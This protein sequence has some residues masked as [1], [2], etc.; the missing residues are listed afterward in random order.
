MDIEKGILCLLF[1]IFFKNE[2]AETFFD[3]LTS[4][5]GE[6]R[7]KCTTCKFKSSNKKSCSIHMNTHGVELN[8]TAEMIQY[9]APPNF[10]MVFGYICE[11]CHYVQLGKNEVE[12]HCNIYHL[13]SYKVWYQYFTKYY[14]LTLLF[15]FYNIGDKKIDARPLWLWKPFIVILILND[16]H[17][18]TA[19]C[20]VLSWFS[21]LL[22]AYKNVVHLLYVMFIGLQHG[23]YILL[24]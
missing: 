2:Y 3:H 13:D 24:A 14:I 7:F 11:E 17:H 23:K 4:H 8:T 10:N 15:Y 1:Q 19:Y 18:C 9:P 16:L 20:C 6:Y 12:Q 21:R 5:T 22:L